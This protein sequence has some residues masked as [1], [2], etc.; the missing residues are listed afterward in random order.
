MS[1]AYEEKPS[2][3]EVTELL[4]RKITLLASKKVD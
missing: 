3:R 1:D 2:L 4:S